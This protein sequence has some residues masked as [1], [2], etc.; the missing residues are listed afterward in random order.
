[1]LK[2]MLK[3]VPTG[4]P[5]IL[6]VSTAGQT[7][8]WVQKTPIRSLNGH[9]GSCAALLTVTAE[10]ENLLSTITFQERTQLVLPICFT[11]KH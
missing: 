1:M 9:H 3:V 6:V 8:M 5:S 11:M 4:F 7:S 10:A 2:V